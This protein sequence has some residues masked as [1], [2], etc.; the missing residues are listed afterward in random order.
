M[1]DSIPNEREAALWRAAERAMATWELYYGTRP[2][3]EAS[4]L[5]GALRRDGWPMESN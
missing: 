2:T 1:A 3:P 5:P 4:D